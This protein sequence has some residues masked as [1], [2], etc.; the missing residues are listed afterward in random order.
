MSRREH[1]N[2]ATERKHI[3][4]LLLFILVTIVLGLAS[5][6][7]WFLYDHSEISTPKQFPYTLPTFATH[8]EVANAINERLTLSTVRPSQVT[9]DDVQPTGNYVIRIRPEYT[10]VSYSFGRYGYI[11][12][13]GGF[14]SNLGDL[15]LC[16][17]IGAI[18]NQDKS[19]LDAIKASNP[20]ANI[21]INELGIS[22]EI[23]S[24]INY[25]IA[26]NPDRIEI[27]I[28]GAADGQTAP[29][30]RPLD[31]DFDFTEISYFPSF[32]PKSRNP[33]RYRRSP[34]IMRIPAG[35]YSNRH[36]PNLRARFIK[37]DIIDDSLI[38]CF[39]NNPS[40]Q[41]ITSTHILEGYEFREID[42]T[43]RI[44]EIYIHIYDNE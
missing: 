10:L 44:V 22:L 23:L 41:T 35:I 34:K 42:P 7:V 36:L 14:N 43:N 19:F 26:S 1:R 25:F 15:D 8:T 4:V 21:G 40:L 32:N 13:S 24:I 9:I 31:P 6:I 17:V 16:S 27:L 12:D 5:S 38:T 11:F 39:T 37:T 30:E 33:T 20:T 18:S 3:P 29:W 2:E 28:K